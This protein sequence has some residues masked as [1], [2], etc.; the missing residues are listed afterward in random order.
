M[1]RYNN[2]TD[3]IQIYD[4]TEWVDWKSGGQTDLPLIPVMTSTTLPE[5][6]V[7]GSNVAS[8]SYLFFD[9]STSTYVQ[10]NATGGYCY[11]QYLFNKAV[12][13]SSIELNMGSQMNNQ[14]GIT[15]EIYVMKEDS[16]WINIKN[17]VF[18]TPE[19]YSP[20]TLKF[21]FDLQKIYGIKI[22]S[23]DTT[24]NRILFYNAQVFGKE[25]I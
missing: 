24:S 10:S 19:R 5:G 6:T 9:G 12:I 17:T 1:I 13:M 11:I 15:L 20:V 3:I 16:N 21:D 14:T 25:Y 4:G 7:S 18:E 8:N 2:D 23:K 22:L